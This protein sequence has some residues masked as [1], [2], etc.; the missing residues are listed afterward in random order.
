[1]YY[2]KRNSGYYIVGFPFQCLGGV[3]GGRE[4]L[5]EAIS[6]LNLL[7][8]TAASAQP[9]TTAITSLPDSASALSEWI[10]EKRLDMSHP[11]WHVSSD[12]PIKSKF[13]TIVTKSRYILACHI[14][15]FPGPCESKTLVVPLTSHILLSFFGSA[16]QHV[17]DLSSLTRDRMHAPCI[18]S[19]ES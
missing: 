15:W 6:P 9:Q 10:F 1:M 2:S 12:S 3:A 5:W 7:L 17:W 8:T 18:V 16:T 11:C 13:L 4:K 19:K 14:S